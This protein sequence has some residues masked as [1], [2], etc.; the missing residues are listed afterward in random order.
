MFYGEGM[1][2]LNVVPFYASSVTLPLQ[3]ATGVHFLIGENTEDT[4]LG[5]NFKIFL[6]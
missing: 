3:L 6:K 1:L 2:P 4:D 5:C